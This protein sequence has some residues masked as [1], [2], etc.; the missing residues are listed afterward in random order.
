MTTNG[1]VN[2]DSTSTEPDFTTDVVVVGTGPAG[3]SIASFLGAYGMGLQTLR[4]QGNVQLME[5]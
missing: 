5:E 2:G 4:F 1:Y 3:G